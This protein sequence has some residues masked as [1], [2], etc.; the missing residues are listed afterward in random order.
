MDLNDSQNKF[1]D[2]ITS[3]QPITLTYLVFAMPEI[4]SY[5]LIYDLLYLKSEQF[6]DSIGKY[7]RTFNIKNNKQSIGLTR[8]IPLLLS[9]FNPQKQ[10]PLIS[11]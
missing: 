6:I 10:T 3:N 11:H 9:T 1:M 4:S 8:L 2:F 5:T 7:K